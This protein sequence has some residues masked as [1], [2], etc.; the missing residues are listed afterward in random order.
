MT[1]VGE[2]EHT[3]G[4]AEPREDHL[5]FETLILD[6]SS[7]FVNLPS[8]EVDDAIQEALQRVCEFLDIDL[9]VLWQTTALD[10]TDL[11]Q[12]HWYVRGGG[13]GPGVLRQE[14]WPYVASEMLA[15]RTFRLASLDDFPPEAAVDRENAELYGLKSNLTVP[16]LV[17][18]ASHVGALGFND[19]RAA[20][21]WPDA[22][23]ARIELIA[24]VFGAALARKRA[25]E[26]LSQ[27]EERLRLA[28]DSAGAGLWTFDYA[29]GTF[30][31]TERGRRLFGFPADGPITLED[32]R[33]VL[34]PDDVQTVLK[35]IEGAWRPGGSVDIEYRILRTD[36]E[37]WMSSQGRTHIGPKGQ[38]GW[39][40]GISRDVTDRRRE[41]EELRA[42]EGRLAAAVELA[43]IGFSYVSRAERTAFLDRR[44]CVLIGV[45]P[46][47]VHDF[48]TL[49]FWQ[50]HQH[51]DDVEA[52]QKETQRLYDGTKDSYRLEYRY[53]HPELGERWLD[54]I[55]LVTRR[56]DSGQVLETLSVARDVTER[57]RAVDALRLSEA[58]LSVAV[59]IAALGFIEVDERAFTA[60]EPDSVFT[61]SRF[62]E[63]LGIPPE[64]EQTDR[65]IVQLLDR[66]PAS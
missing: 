50:E 32:L 37:R 15:G 20:R 17:G 45:P 4:P 27:S 34:H 35:A 56:D 11:W 3:R 25:D 10:E 41:Q 44:M 26:A 5:E 8:D 31:A 61:D 21:D 1:R 12:T 57:R 64:L 53:L 63:L 28:A 6:L 43:G 33:S 51:P 22:L 52:V 16:L 66:P 54:H 42:S 39:L 46:D 58:R 59:D 48:G 49:A 19:F 9:A 23:V 62:R 65:Q 40:M 13:E 14:Q 2:T 38:R 18:G 30:W 47:Q 55:A 29:A 60:G 7:R 36:G 24:Q